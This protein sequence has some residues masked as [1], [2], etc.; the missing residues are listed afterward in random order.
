MSAAK[1][2]R[3]KR[4][5]ETRFYDATHGRYVSLAEL[6]DWAAKGVAVSIVDASTGEE[7]GRVRA[8]K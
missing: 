7:I 6:R 4:Y 8:W 1:K 3:V 2:V 5:A